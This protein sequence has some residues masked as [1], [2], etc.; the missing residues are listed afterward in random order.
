[1]YA[2]ATYFHQRSYLRRRRN[3]EPATRAL[4]ILFS[5]FAMLPL[6]SLLIMDSP[7]IISEMNSAKDSQTICLGGKVYFLQEAPQ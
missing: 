4:V 6:A 3:C 2:S 5:S 7:L 1:M